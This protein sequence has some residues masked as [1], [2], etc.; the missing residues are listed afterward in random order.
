MNVQEKNTFNTV[1]QL[2]HFAWGCMIVL[3]ANLFSENIKTDLE[4]AFVWILYAGIKEFWY[5]ANFETVEIRGSS[6]EDFVFQLMGSAV[7][8]ILILIKILL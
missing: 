7:G 2:S 4:I 6:I 8:I 3:V 1:A 5:D